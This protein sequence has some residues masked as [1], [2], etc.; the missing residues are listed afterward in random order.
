MK[1]FLKPAG[2]LSLLGGILK[3][4]AVLA[5][6]LGASS[7]LQ[8]QISVGP[9]GVTLTFDTQP[10]ASEFA[11]ILV[12]GVNS[13]FTT[14]AAIDVAIV[15]N[16]AVGITAALPAD[17]TTT[18]APGTLNSFRWRSDVSTH[19]L[20]SRSTGGSYI[21]MRGAFANNSGGDANT[22]DIAY[23]FGVLANPLQ[24]IVED[25]GLAG[26]RV[27]Y[28]FTGLAN[29][30]T[31]IP[32]LSTGT[33]GHLTAT[34]NA[35]WVASSTLYLLWV[36]DN[37]VPGSGDG[38]GGAAANV[39]GAYSIDNLNI[40]PHVGVATCPGIT[41]QPANV[42]VQ[43]C[44]P[45]S[46]TFSI[47]ATG[48][49]S[50]VQWYRSN[51]VAGFQAIS[52]ANSLTYV[53]PVVVS[54]DNGSL[55]RALVTNSAGCSATSTVAK[56]TFAPDLTSPTVLYASASANLT[57]VTVVFSKVINTN[58][59]TLGE[60]V[61]NMALTDTNTLAN[62]PIIQVYAPAGG[63]SYLLETGPLDPTHGYTLYVSATVDACP[64]HAL[65][66]VTVPVYSHRSKPLP[67][68]A[69]WKYLQNVVDPG[70]SWFQSGFND[71]AWQV[72][73]GPFDMKRFANYPAPDTDCRSNTL[74]G[75]QGPIPTCLARTNSVTGE[76]NLVVYFRT[77]F[78]YTGNTNK[79]ILELAGKLDDGGVIYLNGQEL[80]R[81]GVAATPAIIT[82]T[83]V[84]TR[85]V[86]DADAQDTASFVSTPTLR[87]GD[88]GTK[89]T[90]VNS[91]P[92]VRSLL[93]G[94]F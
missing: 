33:A 65:D 34:L 35:T 18:T 67:L 93:P 43:E 90:A 73:S 2:G 31:L 71:S 55:F 17:A 84:P 8:A 24:T 3:Y 94:L 6:L 88:S 12:G 28:S 56:L 51:S 57:N 14:A 20:V 85:S 11:N 92:I 4:S 54:A 76:T 19:Y 9:G 38:A 91:K 45:S 32:S 60:M 49:V 10:L 82:G 66:D 53:T 63:T 48:S 77:H 22:I 7:T 89:V 37:G 23:D 69:S 30:W 26:H 21:G 42:T 27:F 25:A 52:G 41:N 36:D 44:P 87:N 62:V 29:S 74:Y 61:N 72:G 81:I 70:A 83:T 79:T 16:A 15:T 13:T 75:M 78:N 50:G 47:S 39:E 1:T 58:A 40:N 46:A 5:A 86:G 68:T 64:G 59:P 80:T